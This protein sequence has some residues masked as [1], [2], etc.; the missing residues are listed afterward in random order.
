M[1][2]CEACGQTKPDIGPDPCLG[3][4]PSPVIHACC[5]HG[6]YKPYV[7]LTKLGPKPK[8]FYD[9]YLS[10]GCY[11][12]DGQP[13]TYS[14]CDKDC[15][16]ANSHCGALEKFGLLLAYSK[17]DAINYFEKVKEI[18]NETKQDRL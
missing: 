18:E 9:F 17:Q 8:E 14:D 2:K 16:R 13:S 1:V 3:W 10:Q 6:K 7:V 12:S 5:G 11:S 4:L 15:E